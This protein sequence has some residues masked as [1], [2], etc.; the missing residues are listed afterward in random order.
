[1]FSNLPN[2]NRRRLARTYSQCGIAVAL[3]MT[4]AACD[5]DSTPAT[6]KA[7]PAPVPSQSISSV[8]VP[9]VMST[10]N[11]G[12]A[13]QCPP[14]YF[15]TGINLA[16]N[17]S[18]EVGPGPKSWPPG[19][20]PVPS[21]ATGWYMHSS[22]DS[23]FVYSKLVPT[24]VPGPGGTNMLYFRAGG[25]EGGVYQQ[26]PTAPSR[27]MFSAWVKVISGQVVIG[28]NGWVNHTPYSWST[29]KGEWEQLRVCTDGTYPTGYFFIVN[30]VATG[31]AFYVDRV[32]IKQ[33]P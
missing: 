3:G 11:G 29:K 26:I 15:I 13:Q 6:P 12:A 9:T 5:A 7:A 23:A 22:N 16:T 25:N 2:T 28:A 10:T 21:A 32:E 17:P 27:V 1:M 4:V 20:F 18:F 19:P 8:S 33:I 24:D 31:G 14:M 30:E